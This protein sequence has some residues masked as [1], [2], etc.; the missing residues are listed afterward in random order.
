MTGGHVQLVD[1]VKRFG[2]FVAVRSI[3]ADVSAG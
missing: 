1:L 2:D 3:S